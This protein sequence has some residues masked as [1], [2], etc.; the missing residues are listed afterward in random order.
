MTQVTRSKWWFNRHY[1]WLIFLVNQACVKNCHVWCHDTKL[2]KSLDWEVFPLKK[3]MALNLCGRD[4]CNLYST[5][6]AAYVWLWRI[7]LAPFLECLILNTKWPF[8]PHFENFMNF[9]LSCTVCALDFQTLCANLGGPYPAVGWQ[10]SSQ[11]IYKYM[12]T[13]LL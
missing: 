9:D 13:S 2:F 5:F 4:E 12:Y 7:F 8:V 10:T 3:N 1:L 11:K 6:T